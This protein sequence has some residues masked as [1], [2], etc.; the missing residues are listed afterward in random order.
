M[1]EYQK[2]YSAFC[3]LEPLVIMNCPAYQIIL[4]EIY[5]VHVAEKSK[6]YYAV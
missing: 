4:C 2:T 6:L 1:M 5:G 3:T